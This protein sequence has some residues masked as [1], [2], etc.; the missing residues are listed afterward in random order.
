MYLAYAAKGSDGVGTELA[1]GRLS[2]HRL[3]GVE[4]LFRQAPKGRAGQH[5]GGR[6]V[7]DREGFVYL[8][9]GDRG[10]RERAQRPTTMRAR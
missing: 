7:F 6:I 1:R 4:V 2:G 3:E 8:T 5:F 10:E 9:L